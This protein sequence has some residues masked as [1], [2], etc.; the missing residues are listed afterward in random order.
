MDLP[1]D[2]MKL[3]PKVD[4]E[5]FQQYVTENQIKAAITPSSETRK[6]RAWDTHRIDVEL[7]NRQGLRV[8]TRMWVTKDVALYAAYNKME[9]SVST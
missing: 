5:K 4:Q 6:V 9:M 7:S 1:V 8:S 3:V 2:W